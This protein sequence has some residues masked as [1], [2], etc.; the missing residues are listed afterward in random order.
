[1]TSIEQHTALARLAKFREHW[2]AEL[3]DTDV[4]LKGVAT[5][6][7]ESLC[8]EFQS[9]CWEKQDVTSIRMPLNVH[10]EKLFSRD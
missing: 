1:M 7:A 6:I 10:C 2:T 5:S 4:H 9:N 3:A 8:H